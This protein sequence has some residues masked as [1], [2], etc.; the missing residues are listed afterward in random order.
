MLLVYDIKSPYKTD[1]LNA[2]SKSGLTYSEM[3]ISWENKRQTF[4]IA[5][6]CLQDAWITGVFAVKRNMIGDKI[7]MGNITFTSFQ[8]SILR[9]DN[10]RVGNSILHYSYLENF[11]FIK[12][13]G[14]AMFHASEPDNRS[15]R[16]TLQDV[17][18]E[19]PDGE[20]FVKDIIS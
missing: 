1:D 12:L 13:N 2:L 10:V 7:E 15:L 6:Y 8:D 18:W 19:S 17:L 20:Q 14:S 9:A 4:K 11:A 5:H 3:F 16:Y